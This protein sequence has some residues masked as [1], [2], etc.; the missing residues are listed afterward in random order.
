[1]KPLP[2]ATPCHAAWADMRPVPGGRHCDACDRKV[3][4][5]S[6]CSEGR[7]RAL[8]I[9]YGRGGFCARQVVVDGD[10]VL[11]PRPP[12]PWSAPTALGAMAVLLAA[13]AVQ[14]Q[15]PGLPDQ[16][17]V[18]ATAA[19]QDGDGVQDA[20]DRCPDRAAVTPD[21]CPQVVVVELGGIS[22]PTVQSIE[23][24]RG[25]SA[26]PVAARALV[27]EIAAV[28]ADN[29]QIGKLALSGHAAMDEGSPEKAKALGMARASA[30]R[31]ALVGLGVDPE[32]LI[33]ASWGSERPI[34]TN[35]T[36][37]GRA[38]NRRVELEICDHGCALPPDA[39]AP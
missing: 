16:G 19:D 23:F 12:R 28:L 24:E 34:D 32:R 21:G 36:A 15:D 26:L 22:A 30:V 17:E 31:D 37:E 9:V 1:M 10:L 13:P 29:P 8:Q 6:R 33:V 39:P 35:K 4:D 14:A 38:H 25:K 18:P 11:A 27:S 7:V 20:D 3:H 2:V 5:L